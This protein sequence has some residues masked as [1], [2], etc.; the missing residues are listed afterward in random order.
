VK[1]RVFTSAAFPDEILAGLRD[2]AELVVWQGADIPTADEITAS[3]S[4][5]AGLLCLLTNPIDAAL[6]ES[7]PDLRWVSSMS[8][9]V[10]HVDVA[11]LTSRGIPLGHT[12]GVLVDTTADLAF[13]LLL[14]A[15]RRVAEGDRFVRSGSWSPETPWAP[16]F[17]VGKDVSSATLGILGLGDIGQAVA[18]RAQ[19]CNMRT[20]SWARAGRQISGVET[21]SFETVL[22]QADFVSVHVALNE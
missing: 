7:C 11:A 8:V 4:G 16:D 20:H 19:G 13:A 3:L 17:F 12:P 6:I 9:G 5:C 2:S 15:A 18:R 22:E 14:A 1:P 21:V 10:D